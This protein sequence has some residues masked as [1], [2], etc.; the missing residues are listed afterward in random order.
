MEP[1]EITPGEPIEITPDDTFDMTITIPPLKRPEIE[2][3]VS[4]LRFK[5]DDGEEW[6]HFEAVL[7][8]DVIEVGPVKIKIHEP[9]PVV[10]DTS[11]KR[12]VE[13]LIKMLGNCVAAVYL[14]LLERDPE[15]AK[16]MELKR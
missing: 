6:A 3:L 9:K 5:R 16:A 13:K 2:V 8:D 1:I 7:A 14:K 4:E 10:T 15:A 11:K 12:A